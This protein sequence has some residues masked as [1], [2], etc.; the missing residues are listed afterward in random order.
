MMTQQGGDDRAWGVMTQ[1]GV[2]TEQGVMTEQGGDDRAWDDDRAW[3]DDRAEGR[4]KIRDWM[5]EHAKEKTDQKDN[6]ITVKSN[7]GF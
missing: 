1:Q 7:M 2:V 4:W 6:R 3:G 5:T